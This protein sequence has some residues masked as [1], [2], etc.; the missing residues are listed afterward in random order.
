MEVKE[1]IVLTPKNKTSNSTTLWIERKPVENVTPGEK[2][3]VAG[4]DHQGIILTNIDPTL[5]N[6]SP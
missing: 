6:I 2:V 5:S 3:Y 4:G 1:H